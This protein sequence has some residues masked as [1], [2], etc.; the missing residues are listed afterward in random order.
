MCGACLGD[1]APNIGYLASGSA[2]EAPF[3][4]FHVA[5]CAEKIV[6]IALERLGE[7]PYVAKAELNAALTELSCHELRDAGCFD[8]FLRN[9][10]LMEMVGDKRCETVRVL[11]ILQQGQWSSRQPIVF[12]CA[13]LW[14]K[15]QAGELSGADD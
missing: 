11:S 14:D 2:V 9:V 7:L 10:T 5:Q 3:I 12:R 8:L 1:A 6:R 15:A 13:S 4:F